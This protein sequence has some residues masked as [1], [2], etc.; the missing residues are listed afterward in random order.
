MSGKN[1]LDGDSMIVKIMWKDLTRRFA[2]LEVS[3]ADTV[4]LMFLI[5]M[6]VIVEKRSLHHSYNKK[7]RISLEVC[8]ERSVF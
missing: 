4:H 7:I 8:I 6:I 2:K 5:N 1:R 3:S